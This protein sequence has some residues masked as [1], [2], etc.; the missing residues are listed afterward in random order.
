MNL[1][2]WT[3]FDPCS[4]EH[5][6]SGEFILVAGSNK[7]VQIYSREGVY[8]NTLVTAA[9]WI[10]TL[11]QRPK[12]RTIAFGT[13]GGKWELTG[14]HSIVIWCTIPQKVSWSSIN[15]YS[16]QFMVYIKIDMPIEML[17]LMLS[18]SIWYLNRKFSLI[19]FWNCLH[20]LSYI[21]M[22]RFLIGSNSY[23]RL[24]E[25]DCYL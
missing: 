12:A 24:C 14:T 15:L 18:Y 13:N 22:K 9:H 8:L 16:I 25:E 17:C 2:F 10:W 19:L 1:L 20:L 21:L 6:N 23:S 4:I 3:G 5:F 11:K 7:E